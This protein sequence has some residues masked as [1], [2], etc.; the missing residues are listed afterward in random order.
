MY[1]LLVIWGWDSLQSYM[2]YYVFYTHRIKRGNK[3]FITWLHLN[4]NTHLTDIQTESKSDPGS[5]FLHL[6]WG[7][8]SW[9]V[10]S[11]Q[12]QAGWRTRCADGRAA[13]E[14]STVDESTTVSQPQRIGRLDAYTQITPRATQ[15]IW[16]DHFWRCFKIPTSMRPIKYFLGLNR[17]RIMMMQKYI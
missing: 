3:K 6:G 11:P 14:E 1:T 5:T 7:R 10:V 16:G 13:S 17:F 9:P 8:S 12:T 4:T 2:F 15:N